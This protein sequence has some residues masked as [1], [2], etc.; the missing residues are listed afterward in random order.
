MTTIVATTALL[1]M[2]MVHGSWCVGGVDVLFGST[3]GEHPT[4]S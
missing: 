1:A 4:G 2:V 3:A